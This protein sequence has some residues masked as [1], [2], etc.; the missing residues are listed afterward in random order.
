M[1]AAR[2]T[3]VAQHCHVACVGRQVAFRGERYLAD[4]VASRLSVRGLRRYRNALLLSCM[5]VCGMCVTVWLGVFANVQLEM[6]SAICQRRGTKLFRG[7]ATC[8]HQQGD[9]ILHSRALHTCC[10]LRLALRLAQL[11]G[12]PLRL[13]KGLPAPMTLR[14]RLGTIHVPK[15]LWIPHGQ[16]HTIHMS[17]AGG[18]AVRVATRA[19]QT[20][21]PHRAV[22]AMPGC[23]VVVPIFED[24]SLAGC[25]MVLLKTHGQ[26]VD[27]WVLHRGLWGSRCYVA[28]QPAASAVYVKALRRLFAELTGRKVH[29]RGCIVV[30]H[31]GELPPA[32]LLYL[33]SRHDK[34]GLHA[35]TGALLY[36]GISVPGLLNLPSKR[37][38]DVV[39]EASA[40]G[41]KR[42]PASLSRPL[43]SSR[44]DHRARMLRQEFGYSEKDLETFDILGPGVREAATP[45]MQADTMAAMGSW[46]SFEY[47]DAVASR[48]YHFDLDSRLA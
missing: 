44:S 30:Q 39:D 10:L 16:V 5:A 18:E 17:S 14:D 47:H 8:G 4:C 36:L 15:S 13:A 45:A 25:D 7:H 32:Q 22:G 3:G 34:L 24:C 11:V 1:T 38:Q 41:G 9:L 48:K 19:L 33:A 20:L 2:K 26:E 28:A 23:V 42:A 12:V 43:P 35:S 46:R 27:A 31:N 29:V 21:E 37:S 6:C 40:A